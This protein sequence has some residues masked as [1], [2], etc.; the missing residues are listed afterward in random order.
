MKYRKA[1][2]DLTRPS[3]WVRQAWTTTPAAYDIIANGPE[4]IANQ[5]GRMCKYIYV[6]TAGTLVYTDQWGNDQ[7]V[8]CGANER[9][10][11]EC[12]ALKATSTAQGV[13]VFW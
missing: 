2:S 11:I 8:T 5:Q 7:T 1:E 4:Y 12:I 13:K 6:V 3:G 10:D 9:V